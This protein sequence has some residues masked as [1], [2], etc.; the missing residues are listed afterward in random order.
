MAVQKISN[1]V[2]NTATGAFRYTA[3]AAQG[4]SPADPATLAPN[5]PAGVRE[6]AAVITFPRAIAT[7][8]PSP[9][10]AT[11]WAVASMMVIYTFV[12]DMTVGP[13]CYALVPEMPASR[14]RT[15]TVVLGRNLYNMINIVMNIIIPYMLNPGAWNWKAKSGFFH[16][17]LSYYAKLHALFA[18]KVSARKFSK[19][20]VELFGSRKL[21]FSDDKGSS[22][23]VAKKD[24][25]HMEYVE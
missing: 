20:H 3:M 24:A 19:T 22:K 6:T 25:G 14:L 8:I 9:T 15:R 11:S 17:G 5:I 13:V 4:T 12:Y 21:L 1:T 16:A 23:V 2:Q 10:T 7:G 18:Q